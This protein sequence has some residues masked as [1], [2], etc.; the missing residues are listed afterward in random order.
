MMLRHRKFFVH[1]IVLRITTLIVIVSRKKKRVDPNVKAKNT[2]KET[3][4]GPCI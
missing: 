1:A 2:F 3:K 4:L